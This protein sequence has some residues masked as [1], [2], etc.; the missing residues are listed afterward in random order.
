MTVILSF[1][2]DGPQTPPEPRQASIAPEL[3]A[4]NRGIAQAGLALATA[5]QE[6][7]RFGELGLRVLNLLDRT[8][9]GPETVELRTALESQ[10]HAIM[11]A[12]TFL[13]ILTNLG[14][15]PDTG[16]QG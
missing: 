7:V 2:K 5:M 4:A 14:L 3:I 6:G 13:S 12:G 9:V 16:A 1:P 11:A 10:A 8:P 15:A